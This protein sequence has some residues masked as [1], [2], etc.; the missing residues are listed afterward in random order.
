VTNDE[1]LQEDRMFLLARNLLEA[2]KAGKITWALTDEEKTFLYAGTRSSVVI[3]TYNDSYEGPSTILSL[4]NSQGTT[5]DSLE[6]E[7][8]RE[9]DRWISAPWNDILDDLYHAARRVSY[10][11][12]EAID[13]ML[14]DIARGTPSPPVKPKPKPTV[15]DPWSSDSDGDGFSDEPPF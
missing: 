13:S 1:D 15:D 4:L 3:K 14:D 7:H 2:T 12:D 6:T 9:G 11:V 8:T 10:N 5:V